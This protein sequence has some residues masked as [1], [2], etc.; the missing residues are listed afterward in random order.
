MIVEADMKTR[1]IYFDCDGLR[2]RAIVGLA[3]SEQAKREGGDIFFAFGI[4]HQPV[5]GY[6][7]TKGIEPTYSYYMEKMESKHNNE[8]T[9]VI[10]YLS[11]L[12]LQ[13]GHNEID[14]VSEGRRLGEYFKG[15]TSRRQLGFMT[16][17]RNVVAELEAGAL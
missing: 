4:G 9:D 17:F 16:V 1:A 11:L 2:F 13:A 5:A 10:G 3:D 6:F 15:L 12:A 7:F 14:L 8:P